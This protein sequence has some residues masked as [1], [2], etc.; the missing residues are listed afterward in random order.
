MEVANVPSVS[1]LSSNNVEQL[2]YNILV[3]TRNEYRSRGM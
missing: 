3:S 2:V 1:E